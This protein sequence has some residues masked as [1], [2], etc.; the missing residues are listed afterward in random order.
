MYGAAGIVRLLVENGACSDSR[1]YSPLLT[2]EQQHWIRVCA[3][4]G[5]VEMLKLLLHLSETYGLGLY[6][7]SAGCSED[8][9]SSSAEQDPAL[10]HALELSHWDMV[11]WLVVEKKLLVSDLAASLAFWHILRSEPGQRHLPV[12]LFR[13][14]IQAYLSARTYKPK[15]QELKRRLAFLTSSLKEVFHVTVEMGPQSK[16]RQFVSY[17][18]ILLRMWPESEMESLGSIVVELCCDSRDCEQKRR[19]AFPCEGRVKRELW[20]RVLRRKCNGSIDEVAV[21]LA[22][23][24]ILLL[25]KSVLSCRCHFFKSMFL[26]SWKEKQTS[27]V[28]LRRFDSTTM[29]ALFE[30]IYTGEIDIVENVDSKNESLSGASQLAKDLLSRFNHETNSFMNTDPKMIHVPRFAAMQVCFNLIEAADYFIVGEKLRSY[31]AS[32]II[33]IASMFI[34]GQCET[35]QILLQ[36][37]V[38]ALDEAGL[39]QGATFSFLNSKSFVERV[40]GRLQMLKRDVDEAHSPRGSPTLQ[41]E[42]CFFDGER[43]DTSRLAL[44]TDLQALWD[45]RD[46]CDCVLVT[47]DKCQLRLHTIILEYSAPQFERFEVENRI[48]EAIRVVDISST[49]VSGKV[50]KKLVWFCYSS[51]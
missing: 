42:R 4:R 12:S 29:M 28:D 46:S 6:L 10:L 16:H 8:L 35:T 24:E 31:A 33:S 32:G 48:N 44:K 49:G 36:H 22:S 14:L 38:R 39:V 51:K 3:T 11:R 7:Q 20:S 37:V 25:N 9:N 17:A 15:D 5:Y 2:R 34:V 26:Q 47:C 18:G 23:G 43:L 1:H 21:A 13:D 41:S 45:Q 27:Q 19:S 50:A 40:N 30:Y